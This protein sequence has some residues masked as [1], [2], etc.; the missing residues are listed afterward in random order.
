MIA[1]VTSCCIAS[2]LNVF[3]LIILVISRRSLSIVQAKHF[4]VHRQQE[5]KNWRSQEHSGNYNDRYCT[6]NSASV[7]ARTLLLQPQNDANR[8]SILVQAIQQFLFHKL[9]N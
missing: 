7:Y 8:P 9:V 3:S 1:K 4:I 5:Q 6:T 2:D